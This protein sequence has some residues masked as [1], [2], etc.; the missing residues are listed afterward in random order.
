MKNP[1]CYTVCPVLL[2]Y[3]TPPYY[4][5]FLLLYCLSCHF[6]LH[7]SLRLFRIPNAIMFVL[8]CCVTTLPHTV[9]DSHCFI[10]PPCPVVLL[11]CFLTPLPLP[12]KIPTAILF[13][14]SCFLTPLAFFLHHGLILCR[15]KMVI[16]SSSI[17]N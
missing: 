11:H 13:V 15:I 14:M 8:S 4:G 3:S 17:C 6:V 1:Y 10:F 5:G 12:F 7:H 2:S 16:L 9:R